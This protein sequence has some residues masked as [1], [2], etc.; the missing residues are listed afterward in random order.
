M[1]PTN[2]TLISRSETLATVDIQDKTVE[3]GV[4]K[5]ETVH[6][7]IDKWATLNMGRA[8]ISL[9]GAVAMTWAAVDKLEVVG[10]KWGLGSGADRL[11]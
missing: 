1:V 11:G 9:V 7:L 5:E 4:R 8:L 6:A 2:N 3:A 10:G